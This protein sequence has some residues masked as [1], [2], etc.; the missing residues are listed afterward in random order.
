MIA[1]YHIDYSMDFRKHS[2]S[3]NYQTDDPIACQ[4]FLVELLERGVRIDQIKHEGVALSRHDF[5]K[6]V[7]T[8]AGLLAAKHLC[9]SLKLTPEEEKFRFGFAV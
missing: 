4:E 7:K 1:K 2:Q 3:G 5:D 8:A 9:A 6:L